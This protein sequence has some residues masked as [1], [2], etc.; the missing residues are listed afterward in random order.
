MSESDRRWGDRHL[1]CYPVGVQRGE[2]ES[3]LALIRDLSVSGAML[4]TAQAPKEG[5]LLGLQL[6]IKENSDEAHDAVAK[7]VRVTRRPADAGAWRFSVAVQFEPPLEQW[8]EEIDALRHR[9][10]PIPVGKP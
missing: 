4:F 9:L 5:E 7:V 3:T 2:G 6:H 10:P 8:R 1:A